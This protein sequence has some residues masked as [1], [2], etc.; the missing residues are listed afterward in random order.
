MHDLTT[1]AGRIA[2]LGDCAGSLRRLDLAAGLDP[3]H[4]HALKGRIVDP[5]LSTLHKIADGAGVAR[6]W[7]TNGDGPEPDEHAVKEAVDLAV[8]A[9]KASDIDTLPPASDEPSP[10]VGQV[11]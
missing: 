11:A 9:S 5:K 2:F 6:S 8:A 4:S 10:V 1:V 3:G 7:V